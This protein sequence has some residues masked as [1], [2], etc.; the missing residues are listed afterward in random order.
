LAERFAHEPFEAVADGGLAADLPAD[1]NAQP[2]RT[3]V[4]GS[5][6]K[7]EEIVGGTPIPTQNGLELAIAQQSFALG[8]PQTLQSLRVT[9]ET[10][11]DPDRIGGDPTRPPL[12]YHYRRYAA[13]CYSQSLAHLHRVKCRS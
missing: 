2:G 9:C 11:Y 3:T 12:P 1:R 10:K 6:E 5:H 4:V 13:S 8:K 7:S